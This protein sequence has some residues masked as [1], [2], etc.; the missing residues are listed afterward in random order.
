MTTA[1]LFGS[2]IASR[3]YSNSQKA[4]SKKMTQLSMNAALADPSQHYT[5]TNIPVP[6]F[7]KN[8]LLI[9]VKSAAINPI[10]YKVRSVNIPF[11][12]W[13]NYATVGRDFSGVVVDKGENVKHFIIGDEVY[14]NAKGGSLQEFT[15][16]DKNQ[17]GHKP[18]NMTFSEAASIGLAGAT[19]LQ[20]LKYWGDLNNKKVL[21]IGASGGTGGF[22]VQIAKYYKAKVYAVCSTKNTEY[23]KSL[24][25]DVI[26]DYSKP[27]FLEGI[28]SEKFDLI[29]DTVTSSD[30]AD[31][32]A[33]YRPFLK[34]EG[35]YVAIN[36]RG[37]DFPKCM[38]KS[39]T[40]I[41]LERK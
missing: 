19:S 25:A 37:M 10:D 41:N 28:M 24:G 15:V 39:M 3:L 6:S 29:Y 35:R 33:I 31:H 36:G 23:V 34:N 26:I 27:D 32:E 13:F 21:I 2:I 11:Y 30:D 9:Q 40:G 17:I 22:G 16:V 12:R 5:I 8:E 1:F 38:L 7:T 4:T 14:G 18:S 20:A